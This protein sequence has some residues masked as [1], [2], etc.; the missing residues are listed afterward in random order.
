MITRLR[1][2]ARMYQ[3]LLAAAMRAQGQ[4]RANLIIELIGAIAYQ[5]AGFAF[6][7]VV[8]DRFGQIGGWGLPELALLYGL[9]LGAHGVFTSLFAQLMGPISEVVREGEFDRYLTRPVDP[10][11]QLITRRF[12]LTVIG[13]L[14][15]GIVLIV[16]GASRVDVAWTTPAV[17]YLLLAIVG[18]A[19]VEASLH[20]AASALSFRMITTQAVSGAIDQLLST[21]GGYPQKIFPTGFQLGL[22]FVFPLAFIA[23]FPAAVLLGRGDELVVPVWLAG[24]SPV[25]G[26]L[27]LLAAY[28]FWRSQIRHYASTGH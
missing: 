19:L 16:A 15:G 24:L 1:R 14:I 6:V 5:G 17:A 27:L 3:V 4:Y 13:D 18:G 28:A 23:Y 22:T 11:L 7:W 26:F 2:E 9:R 8:V 25:V 12:N 10:L 21:L 20:L